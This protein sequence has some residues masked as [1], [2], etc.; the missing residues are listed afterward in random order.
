MIFKKQKKV[1]NGHDGYQDEDDVIR[2]GIKQIQ[3]KRVK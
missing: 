3:E 2:E 1:L